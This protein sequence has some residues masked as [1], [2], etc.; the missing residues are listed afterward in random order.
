MNGAGLKLL[1]LL[2]C[3]VR[4]PLEQAFDIL[5]SESAGPAQR[6]ENFGNLLILLPGASTMPRSLRASSIPPSDGMGAFISGNTIGGQG[7]RKA[8]S[9]IPRW[10]RAQDYARLSDTLWKG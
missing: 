8:L 3:P 5:L 1:A 9:G 7:F 6:R 10:F 2:P 4:A